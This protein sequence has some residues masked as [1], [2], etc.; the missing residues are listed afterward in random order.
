MLK[1]GLAGQL[2]AIEFPELPRERERT[3]ES[4]TDSRRAEQA[5]KGR[6]VQGRPRQT[7]IV[8]AVAHKGPALM[9]L[10]LDIS[11]AGLP[12]GIERGEGQIEIMLCRLARVDRAALAFGS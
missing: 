2:G 6:A 9:R 4:N 11:L 1:A 8:E 5:L 7:A 3:L 10:A 12:L